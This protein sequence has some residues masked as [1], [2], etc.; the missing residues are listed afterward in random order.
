MHAK[1]LKDGYCTITLGFI[2][3]DIV[4]NYERIADHCTNIAFY[5]LRRNNITYEAHSYAVKAI[6]SPVYQ[7]KIHEYQEKYLSFL[8]GISL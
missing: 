6:S 8:H 2:Y 1:R 7:E 3:N 5:T 4:N